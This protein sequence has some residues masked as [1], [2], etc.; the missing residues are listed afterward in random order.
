MVVTGRLRSLDRLAFLWNPVGQN[1]N[2]SAFT[3]SKVLVAISLGAFFSA[4]TNL[5]PLQQAST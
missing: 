2:T 1:R 3:G 5:F 4:F